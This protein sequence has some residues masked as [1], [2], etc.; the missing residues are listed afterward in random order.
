MRLLSIEEK[1]KRG[2]EYCSDIR[3]IGSLTKEEQKK[4]MQD[5]RELYKQR[6]LG[7][8]V[9]R[10]SNVGYCIYDQC[11]YRELDAQDNYNAKVDSRLISILLGVYRGEK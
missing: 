7:V 4:I 9:K 3:R 11:P 10:A 2:C 6:S 5:R 1:N 8:E